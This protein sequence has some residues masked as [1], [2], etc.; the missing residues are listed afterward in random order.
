MVSNCIGSNYTKT[1]ALMALL[2]AA[3]LAIGHAM[4]GIQGMLL[5]GSIGLIFNFGAWW[6]SDRIALAVNRAQPVSREELPEVYET[7]EELTTRAQMPMPR[8]Y[9]IPDESP[10][11]FA[12]GRNPDHAAVAVTAGSLRILNRR[13]LRAVLG[14]ELA[15]VLNRDTL[16]STI[17]AAIAGLISAAA[18]IIRWGIILGTG[19]S[20]DREDSHPLADLAI[21]IVAPII[22]MLLQLAVSRSREYGADET[23]AAL[24][25]DPEGL[26]QALERIHE[27]ARQIPYRYAGP[28]TAHLFIVNPFSG[29]ALLSLLSTHPPVEERINRLRRLAAHAV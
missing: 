25:D 8:I 16:I 19:G 10:N 12:T 3:L 2:I 26:A 18:S 17:A 28:A 29:R 11:A 13:Q 27:G 14:H 5:W 7:V 20:R 9:L 24:T 6:F 23:G 4:G 22:A 1:A 21:V 15:H